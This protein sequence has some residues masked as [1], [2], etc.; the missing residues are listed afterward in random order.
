MSK[1]NIKRKILVPERSTESK[2]VSADR[3]MFFGLE[4]SES[5]IAGKPRFLRMD[6]WMIGAPAVIG[7]Y[8]SGLSL[9][10][11]ANRD[12][13]APIDFGLKIKEITSKLRSS[14]NHRIS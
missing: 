14:I 4:K 9:K 12:G 2:S 5:V 1:N 3:D 11:E 8:E 10:N 13:N 7:Q 6:E